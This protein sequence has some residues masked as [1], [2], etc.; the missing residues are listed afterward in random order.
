[1][2]LINLLRHEFK[3]IFTNPA[4]MLTVIG[5]VV[6]YSFLYPLPYAEQIPRNQKVIVVNLDNSQLSRKLERMVDATPQVE[7]V[8]RAYSIEEAKRIFIDQKL[9]GILVIPEHFYR[10]LMLG[11][12]PILS[13][14]GDASYFL[15]YGTVLEGLM[16]AGKSLSAQTRV[17]KLVISGQATPLAR[18]Q[19]SAIHMNI[20]SVFNTTDGYVNYVIPGVFIIVLHHTLIMGAGILG[21]TQNEASNAGIAGYWQTAPPLQLLLV[22][23]FLFI[24][25]YWLLCMYYFGFSFD[26]YDI[27]INGDFKILNLLILPFLLAASQM[28]ILLGLILPRRELVTIILLM[29]SFPLVFGA[30]FIW[31]LESIPPEIYS[32]IKFIPAVPAM[33][34]FIVFNQMEGDIAML[35]PLV[36]QLWLCVIL[37]GT[38][39]LIILYLRR[40]K[41]LDAKQ[42]LIQE[43]V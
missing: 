26:F 42:K 25:I 17:Q 43:K 41:A 19:Y 40:K 9:A 13:Y 28:G 11:R 30:G 36:D 8:E 2:T 20:R 21:G 6:F 39:S 29:T 24:A 4:I 31:P 15:V 7:L 16:G 3:A 32:V 22:R 5:G 14:A 37:Y 38:P 18:E 1:M 34:L 12:Q 10:D 27:P 33:K 23:T 35:R